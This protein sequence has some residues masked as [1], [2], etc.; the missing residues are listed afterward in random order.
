[1]QMKSGKATLMVLAGVLILF[2]ASIVYSWGT[3]SVPISDAFGWGKSEISLV[4]MVMMAF[5]CLG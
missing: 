1:M 3:V 4:L 2:N 5:F